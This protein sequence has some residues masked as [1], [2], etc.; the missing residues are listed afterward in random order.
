[1][2]EAPRYRVTAEHAIINSVI[3]PRDS[4]FGW[5]GWPREFAD[6]VEPINDA[7]SRI[8]DYWRRH[9]SDPHAPRSP[10]DSRLGLIFLPALTHCDPRGEWNPPLPAKPTAG[11]PTYT[12][13]NPANFGKRAVP[14]GEV[15][16]FLGWAEPRF[17]LTPQ[18][19]AAHR[20]VSYFEANAGKPYFPPS[21]WNDFTDA[22]HLPDLPEPTPMPNAPRLSA[23]TPGAEA[24]QPQIGNRTFE[25]GSRYA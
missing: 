12:T 14:P 6:R 24:P 4:E 21:C 11:M 22:L 7:A 5:S 16:A 19:E 18:N 3:Y 15:F 17:G 9:A 20:V 13:S 23:F 25:R 2:N 8:F 10:F 1:M